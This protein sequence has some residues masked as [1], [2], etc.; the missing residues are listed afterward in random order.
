MDGVRSFSFLYSQGDF[1]TM[2]NILMQFAATK[3]MDFNILKIYQK[4]MFRV[5]KSIVRFYRNGTNW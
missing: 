1:V 5:C 3:F 2:I 4:E